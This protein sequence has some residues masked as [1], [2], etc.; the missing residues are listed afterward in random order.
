MTYASYAGHDIVSGVITLPYW[1]CLVADVGFTVFDQ[2]DLQGSLIIGDMKYESAVYRSSGYAGSR[3]ARLVGGAGGWRKP[4][5]SQGYY[6]ESGVQASMVL[7]DCAA[8]V[9][10]R[11]MLAQDRSVGPHW[12]REAAVASRT[13]RQIAGLQWWVDA[14]GT[15][16][17]GSRTLVSQITSA[18]DVLMRTGGKGT[19]TIATEQL[20]DWTPGRTF[21]LPDS[22]TLSTISTVIITL[23]EGGKSRL[24]V[25]TVG[26][27]ND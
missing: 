13:L 2:I 14:A 5:P 24:E 11:V 6:Q 4:V 25:M 22:S 10:E 12:A 27:E 1:G 3:T 18:F 21:A 15:T 19:V 7:R 23:G 26:S 16:Q 8:A 9:G 17:V 20:A